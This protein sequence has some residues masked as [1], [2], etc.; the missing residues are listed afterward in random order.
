MTKAEHVQRH[1]C[2]PFQS[3]G[4]VF[5]GLKLIRPKS[6]SSIFPSELEPYTEHVQECD[7][8]YSTFLYE[9]WISS[10]NKISMLPLFKKGMAL[11][12]TLVLSLPAVGS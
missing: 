1:S 11:E 3:F 6:M 4:H 12:I 9:T 2:L 5:P 7:Y 10:Q 8:P